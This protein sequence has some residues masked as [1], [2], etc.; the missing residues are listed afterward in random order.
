MEVRYKGELPEWR[1]RATFGLAAQGARAGGDAF[2]A[3][4]HTR[5]AAE[6]LPWCFGEQDYPHWRSVPITADDERTVSYYAGD[7]HERREIALGRLILCSRC[8]AFE[9]CH[10]LTMAKKSANP[11]VVAARRKADML[12]A[13]SRS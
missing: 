1:Y 2:E 9:R 13:L 6:G 8:P 12:A 3:E 4:A 5:L 10:K 11:A 7:N